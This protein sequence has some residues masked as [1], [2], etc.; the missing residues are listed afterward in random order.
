MTCKCSVIITYQTWC[1]FTKIN[2]TKQVHFNR[3]LFSW[4]KSIDSKH[5]NALEKREPIGMIDPL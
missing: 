2:N 4:I 5:F 1:S 3:F